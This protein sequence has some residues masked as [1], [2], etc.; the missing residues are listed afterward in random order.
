MGAE[1]YRVL[2]EK[3]MNATDVHNIIRENKAR[4]KALFAP[5]DPVTGIGSPIE[6]ELIAFS[7]GSTELR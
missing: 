3:K 2:L 5:Y 7:V 1:G 6:R 4:R